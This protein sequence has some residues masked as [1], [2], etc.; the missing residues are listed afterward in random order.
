M[1]GFGSY[2]PAVLFSYYVLVVC[3]SMISM[4]PVIIGASVIGGLLLFWAQNTVRKLLKELGF[5]FVLFLCHF[6]VFYL[7]GPVLPRQVGRRH[8]GVERVLWTSKRNGE[9]AGTGR[10]T[11]G[12]E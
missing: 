2:H 5:F 11:N 8:C 3:F 7:P 10:I 4:H 1:N 6:V 9:R 12:S